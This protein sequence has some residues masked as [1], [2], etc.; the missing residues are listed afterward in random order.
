M[1]ST[2]KVGS[3]TTEDK[4]NEL[5]AATVEDLGQGELKGCE[6]STSRWLEEDAAEKTLKMV[7]GV[8]VI[9]IIF[10]FS[11]CTYDALV[12]SK[13]FEPSLSFKQILLR[14]LL[15]ENKTI[16]FCP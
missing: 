6:L 7:I 1:T 14:H 3:D 10:Q 16:L 11:Y 4:A 5:C 12:K 8:E 15:R 13:P 2:M 9:Q